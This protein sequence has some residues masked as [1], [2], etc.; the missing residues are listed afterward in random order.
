MTEIVLGIILLPG[1]SAAIAFCE[2]WALAFS[3]SASE[4]LGPV[5]ISLIEIYLG[6]PERFPAESL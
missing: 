4:S 2:P 1:V 3:H 5:I 6:S